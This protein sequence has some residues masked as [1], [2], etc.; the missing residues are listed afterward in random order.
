M[1]FSMSNA[2]NKIVHTKFKIAF[3]PCIQSCNGG[4]GFFGCAVANASLAF[5]KDLN[6]FALGDCV[7]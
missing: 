4:L 6:P 1:A 2:H 7:S 3:R 5:A